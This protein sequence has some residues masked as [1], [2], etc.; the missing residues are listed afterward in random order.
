MLMFKTLSIC[1]S[2]GATTDLISHIVSARFAFEELSCRL[3]YFRSVNH[4]WPDCSAKIEEIQQSN[5]DHIMFKEHEFVC[6]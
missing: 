4:I 3:S 5:P 6:S 1:E 2:H